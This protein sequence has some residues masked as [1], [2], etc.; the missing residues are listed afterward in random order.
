MGG[1]GSLIFIVFLFYGASVAWSRAKAFAETNPLA[2]KR[3]KYIAIGLLWLA[4]VVGLMAM[5]ISRRG[6][7]F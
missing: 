4:V 7:H 1:I 6:A 5:K 3:L 2:M